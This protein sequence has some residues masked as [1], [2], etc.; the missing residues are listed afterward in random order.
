VRVDPDN[1]CTDK[2][3][4]SCKDYEFRRMPCKHVYAVLYGEKLLCCDVSLIYG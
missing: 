2:C 3:S 1:V 4:C